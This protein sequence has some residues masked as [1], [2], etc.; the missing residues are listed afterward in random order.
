MRGDKPEF[1]SVIIKEEQ[2][3]SGNGKLFLGFKS[4]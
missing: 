2:E 1:R 4:L 3:C